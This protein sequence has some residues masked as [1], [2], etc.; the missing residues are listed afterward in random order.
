MRMDAETPTVTA[1]S[2]NEVYS[3]TK[4]LRDEITLIAGLGVEGD[5]HAGVNVRHRHRV[6]VDPSQPNLRQVHLIQG[7]LFDEVRGQGYAV[8]PG[9]L[10]ENVTTAGIDLLGLPRGTILRF[11]PPPATDR[12]AGPARQAGEVAREA[13]AGVSH[14]AGLAAAD[15]SQGRT[16]ALV[17]VPQRA[18]PPAGASVAVSDT[19]AGLSRPATAAVAGVVAAAEAAALN[20]PTARALEALVA[21]A[22]RDSSSTASTDARTAVVITGMRNPCVQINGFQTGLLKE[23]IEQDAAGNVVRKAGVMGVVL[24]DGRIRPGDQVTVELP[25]LPHSPLECI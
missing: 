16:E 12:D 7:E 17:G 24:R 21:A 18:T 23:V 20:D 13:A 4:P 8:A 11:G 6:R 5:V 3:F 10:G 19:V 2:R 14:G 9:N 25:P 22:E 15:A 1:V